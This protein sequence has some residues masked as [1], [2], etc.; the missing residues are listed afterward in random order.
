MRLR[1]SIPAGVERF[2]IFFPEKRRG[3]NTGR[4]HSC[5]KAAFK[6]VA[7]VRRRVEL[8]VNIFSVRQC[9]YAAN[10]SRSALADFYYPIRAPPFLTFAHPRK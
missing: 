2:M 9:A 7:V 10:C 8:L 4:F 6:Q 5:R 3:Q 1:R